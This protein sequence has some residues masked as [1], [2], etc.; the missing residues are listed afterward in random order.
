MTNSIKATADFESRSACSLRNSGSWRYS[1]D[2]TT[3]VLCLAYRL[4]YWEKGRTGLWHPAFPHLGIEEGESFDDLAELFVWVVDG[5]LVESHNS[6][7]EAGIWNNICVPHYGW[8][9]LP[10]RQRRCSAAKAAAHS[11]PRKLED[12]AEVSELEI[13]K[14]TEGAKTMKKMAA[15]RKPIKADRS[16]WAKQHSPCAVCAA[17]GRV[18]SFKKDG[19]PTKRGMKCPACAGHGYDNSRPIPVMPR[20][21]HESREL[22]ETL[23]AYCRQDV[24]AEEELSDNLPD[25]NEHETEIYLVDQAV[26]ERGF[27]LDPDAIDAALD[28]IDEEF[29][30]LNAELFELTEGAVERATQRD[31]MM[32]WLEEQGLSLPNTQAATI[33]DYLARTDLTPTVRRGLELLQA[34][35]KSSTAKFVKMR[36]W[37]CPDN[38]VHGGL[39]FHGAGTGRWSGA[40]IQ[41]HNFPKGKL[42]DM[43]DVWNIIKYRDRSALPLIFAD[44]AGNPLTVMDTLSSAL[45]GVIVAAPGKQLYVADYASIEARVLLWAAGDKEALNVFHNNEDIYCYMADDIFGYKTNKDDHPKERGIG[46]IAVLGL[47]YQMGAAKFVDTCALGGVTI[48]EDHFCAQCGRGTREHSRVRDHAFEWEDHADPNDLTAVRIVTAYREKFWRVKE[49]WSDQEAAAIDAVY[50]EGERV[51]CGVVSWFTEDGFLYCELP[52]GRRLAYPEPEVRTQITSWGE[53]RPQLTFMGINPYNRAW[54]RQHTYG[55]SLVENIVQAIARDLL[56]DAMLR[57]ELSGL[58]VPVLTVHD[59]IICEVAD[60]VGNLHEFEQLMAARPD[61]APDCPIAA[62]GFIARRYK[63]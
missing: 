38:R 41:P 10:L 23:W 13:T 62:E 19:T 49:M 36:S 59:E 57:C 14:D 24:L 12:V 56:A 18:E 17:T 45:R 5:G 51:Q 40:G 25:L 37:I 27:R 33:T 47:G 61:W 21:W 60:G 58:Y 22:M 11:L 16:A 35:S 20:L 29:A 54:Q 48:A 53:K 31:R 1:L 4:P 63:K 2:P 43:E 15:P 3:E 55:G 34:L 32:E 42:K 46:K 52:S 6:W 26:N 28:I 39:L 50:L 30:D 7:F 44:K 8:P 9:V